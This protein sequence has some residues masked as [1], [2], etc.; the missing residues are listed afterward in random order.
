MTYFLT[1][2]RKNGGFEGDYCKLK[3]KSDENVMCGDDLL[4][5][6]NQHFSPDLINS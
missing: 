4:E 2:S 5:I 1:S 3:E 6:L